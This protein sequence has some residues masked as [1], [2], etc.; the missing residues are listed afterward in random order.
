MNVESLLQDAGVD[1]VKHEHPVSY[2]AQELAAEEHVTG[3]AVA[4]PVIV[5]ADDRIV[6]CVLPASCKVDL[7]RLA[8][9]L[10]AH[11]CRLADEAELAKLFPD[12]EL[13]AEPPFGHAYGLETYVDERL[14][15]CDTVTFN[16]GSHE[17]AI[18][19]PYAEYARLAEPIVLD[20]SLHA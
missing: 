12:V 3:N 13:G 7:T 15:R 18:R 16:A 14:A 8:K 4:K 17:W 19:L 5:H 10:R 6:M 1:Y 20:F 11:Q 9:A 2:T